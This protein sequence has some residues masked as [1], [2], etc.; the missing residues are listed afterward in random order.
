[1]NW[2]RKMLDLGH[3]VSSLSKL[4]PRTKRRIDNNNRAKENLKIYKVWMDHHYRT[5]EPLPKDG[6]KSYMFEGTPVKDRAF[7]LIL[8]SE[9]EDEVNKP[10]GDVFSV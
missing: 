1:M 7:T 2:G 6:Y 9:Y 5:Y 10:I 4:A 3:T 8:P